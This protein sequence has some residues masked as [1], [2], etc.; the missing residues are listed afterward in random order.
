[1]AKI[2]MNHKT[3]LQEQ[4]SYIFITLRETLNILGTHF[5]NATLRNFRRT[6]I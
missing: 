5:T 6:F 4:I 3:T 2:E 1:M